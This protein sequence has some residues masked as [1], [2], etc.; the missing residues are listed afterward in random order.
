MEALVKLIQKQFDKMCQTGRLFRC[1]IEGD[2]LWMAYLEGFGKN[3]PKWRDPLSSIHNCNYCHGFMRRYGNVVA[4]DQN[5]E[6]MSLWGY[7]A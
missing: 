6:I 2:L 5:L 4:I 7:A 1:D 3:D